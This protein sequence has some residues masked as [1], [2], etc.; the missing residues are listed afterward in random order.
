MIFDLGGIIR[1]Y[2]KQRKNALNLGPNQCTLKVRKEMFEKQK[3]P[4]PPRVQSPKGLHAYIQWIIHSLVTTTVSNLGIIKQI[5]R[6]IL[7]G[8]S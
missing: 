6:K 3:S 8:Q 5:V 4:F 1:H 7:S 2:E